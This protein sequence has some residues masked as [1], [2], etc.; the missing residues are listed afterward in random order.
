MAARENSKSKERLSINLLYPQGTPPRL[1]V[2][3]LSWLLSYGRL[4][5]I[6]VEIIVVA[7]FI[8]RFKLDAELGDL[9]DQNNRQ[10]EYI[11]SL[12]SDE[13]A[14]RQTQFRITAISKVYKETP[15]WDKILS[16]VSQQIPTST[17][18]QTGLKIASVNLTRSKDKEK[19]T[20]FRIAG[21]TDS[22]LNLANFIAGLRQD[23]Y[24]KNVVLSNINFDSGQISFI[25]TGESS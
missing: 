15:Q 17:Q 11:K 13:I 20:T 2:K 6:V 19:I 10:V 4:L 22:N 5:A 12:A 14:I 1:P 16:H 18:G 21:T 8:A 3:F 23:N 24:F 25:I 9:K 7:A